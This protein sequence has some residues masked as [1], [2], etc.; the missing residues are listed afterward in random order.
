MPAQVTYKKA[1]FSSQ[2]WMKNAP[3][4]T[5]DF[6][7]KEKDS[8]T[9]YHYFGARYYNSDLSL[10]LS[11]DPMSDKYPG[12]SPYNYCA[13]NP[14]KI[15]DPD[16]MRFDSVSM[17]IVNDFRKNT[18]S[19]ISEATNDAQRSELQSA[20]DELSILESSD[21]LYHIEYG[22]TSGY[23]RN[24]E[25][26]YDTKNDMVSITMTY[27]SN[28][29]D[30]AHELKHAYQFEVGELSFDSKTGGYGVLYDITDELN[31]YKR[32]SA[33]GGTVPIEKALKLQSKHR[34]EYGS[35]TYPF[36]SPLEVRKDDIGEGRTTPRSVNKYEHIGRLPNN[37]I[38]YNNKSYGR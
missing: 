17:S 28:I 22:N 20:L 21:Q 37:I 29:S 33:Y 2:N 16:G 12:L 4:F 26:G 24:G 5:P 31:A 19:R 15:V 38:R 6:S 7:G 27:S 23:N 25:I 32:G 13:W 14:M 1:T 11:V 3:V 35:Y 9:G 36:L 18:M 10:W 34:N 30:L 8:E